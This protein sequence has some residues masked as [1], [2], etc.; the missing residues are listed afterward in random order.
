[1]TREKKEE[2]VQENKIQL[3]LVALEHSGQETVNARSSLNL[4]PNTAHSLLPKRGEDVVTGDE[5]RL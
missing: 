3:A 5:A 4:R 2:E 1:M